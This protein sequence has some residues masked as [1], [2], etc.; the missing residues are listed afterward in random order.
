MLFSIQALGNTTLMKW[1]LRRAPRQGDKQISAKSIPDGEN[2]KH[3]GPGAIPTGLKTTRKYGEGTQQLWST[4]SNKAQRMRA[5]VKIQAE[6]TAESL[7]SS[8]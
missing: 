3:K 2:K 6:G 7:G 4:A 5:T 1:H 8:I